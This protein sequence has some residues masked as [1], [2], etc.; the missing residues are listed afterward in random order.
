M[1]L[2]QTLSCL[3]FFATSV[4][5]GPVAVSATPDTI[6]Q[7]KT[8][9][10]R[11]VFNAPPDSVKGRLLKKTI[12]FFPLDSLTY[13]ALAG[14]PIKTSPGDHELAVY[15]FRRPKGAEASHSVSMESRLTITV[16]EAP[17]KRDTVNLPEPAMSK[18]TSENLAREAAIIGPGFKTVSEKKMWKTKFLMPTQGTISSPFGAYRIYN[19]GRMS[20]P[21]KG[22]D[23][24][25]STGDSVLACADGT[26]I[27]SEDM[28]VHGKT[29]MIDHGHGI[30]SVHCHLKDRVVGV[31][32]RVKRGALI[33]TVGESGIA[34][35][36]HLHWGVSVGNVR[37]D[38]LEWIERN[39]Q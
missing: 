7:G 11:A 35:G 24:A 22:V 39:I 16:K 14:I 12:I 10:V 28:I 26:V 25:A 33:G 5:S 9:A 8:L 38:P 31:G 27:L 2:I 1:P 30:V 32:D 13:R 17:F 18:L 20:W 21:H 36:P 37:V 4:H 15:A 34:T 23:I 19:D 6:E 3:L 29:V